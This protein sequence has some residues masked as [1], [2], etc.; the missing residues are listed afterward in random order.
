MGMLED[1]GAVGDFTLSPACNVSGI[2]GNA[3][4]FIRR[5]YPFNLGISQNSGIIFNA[6]GSLNAEW[7]DYGL[8]P[9][10]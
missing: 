1:P 4:T 10:F 2:L 5:I 8:E 9:Y 7:R 6:N 3:G